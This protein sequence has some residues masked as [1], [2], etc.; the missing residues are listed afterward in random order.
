MDSANAPQQQVVCLVIGVGVAAVSLSTGLQTGSPGVGPS[1]RDTEE[2][3]V[4]TPLLRALSAA[5]IEAV[6]Q[7]GAGGA[8]SW[9]T[10]VQR[11]LFVLLFTYGSGPSLKKLR[12]HD[13]KVLFAVQSHSSST[14]GRPK[15][16]NQK[17]TFCFRRASVALT[18]FY[19]DDGPSKH[20]KWHQETPSVI[21]AETCQP[22]SPR[23]PR[24]SGS[25]LRAVEPKEL[26][27]SEVVPRP[28][29]GLFFR[30]DGRTTLKRGP[31]KAFFE[32]QSNSNAR[33]KNGTH[34]Q[35]AFWLVVGPPGAFGRFPLSVEHLRY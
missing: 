25:Q 9:V 16:R 15:S 22:R 30:S 14:R 18:K 24:N 7:V 1:L 17:Y 4:V 35:H 8:L 28:H 10:S 6:T 26:R 32:G 21:A 34:S 31:N 12:C 3:S 13:G 33:S 2:P 27:I 11:I 23:S 19:A 20:M 29:L 5:I